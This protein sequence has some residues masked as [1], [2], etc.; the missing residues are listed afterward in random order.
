MNA[1]SALKLTCVGITGGIIFRLASMLFLFD[2]DTG[3]Y[4]DNGIAAWGTMAFLALLAGTAVFW[5][6]RDKRAYFGPYET[7][8]NIGAGVV[9]VVSGLTLLV[10]S[11]VQ[12]KTHTQ[13]VRAGD[14][15]PNFSQSSSLHVLF[16]GASVVFAILQLMTAAGFF[17]GKNLFRN[18]PALHLF[19][20]VWGI[21]NLLFTFFYYAKSAMG[22]ENLYMIAGGAAMVF[23][24]LYMSKLIVGIGGEK[25]AKN[26]YLV[27]I[28]AV[29]INLTYTVSNLIV[30]FLGKDY[31]NYGEIPVAVQ[32]GS[33]AVSLFILSFLFT[34]KKYSLKRKPR[35]A[36]GEREVEKGRGARRYRAS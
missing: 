36:P 17:T 6:L 28:P 24:L 9:S 30:D 27:G 19:S 1:G 21:L 7:R 35:P 20:V 34:F 8:K 29:L 4:R 5:C 31:Y 2:F 26:C 3:F 22:I 32:I 14:I 10:M 33:L 11:A 18:V 23:A 16:I 25:T 15:G 13:Y 12:A